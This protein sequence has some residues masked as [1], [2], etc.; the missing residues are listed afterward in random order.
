MT[1][2]KSRLEDPDWSCRGDFKQGGERAGVAGLMSLTPRPGGSARPEASAHR[3]FPGVT[4]LVQNSMSFFPQWPIYPKDQI[5]SACME[6][7]PV[8]SFPSVS[9]SHL[10]TWHSPHPFPPSRSLLPDS[11]LSGPLSLPC[12]VL[13]TP[14]FIYHTKGCASPSLPGLKSPIPPDSLEPRTPEIGGRKVPLRGP[15]ERR[16]V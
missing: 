11:Q 15:P 14:T 4:V 7:C 5:H 6:F 9:Y 3:H 12:Y 8:V 10:L 16:K 13:P 2:Y 1:S